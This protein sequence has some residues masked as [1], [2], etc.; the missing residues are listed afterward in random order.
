MRVVL[1]FLYLMCLPVFGQVPHDH[2]EHPKGN[3]AAMYQALPFY[4]EAC[5]LYSNGYIE[6]AK[7]SLHEA[8]NISFELTEAQLF[9]ADIY[10]DQGK[11][12]SAFLYYNSGIDFNIEQK[13]HYYFKLFES[14]LQLGQY[15][16]VKHNLGHFKKL[17]SNIGGEEPYEKE[18]KYRREDLEFYD[19]VLS[20]IYNYHYWKPVATLEYTFDEVFQYSSFQANRPIVVSD[21]SVLLL[22]NDFQ[23]KKGAKKVKGL[24]SNCSDLYITPMANLLF[25]QLK[26]EKNK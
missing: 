25:T 16:F 22:R 26:M 10:Y 4:N 11:I 14:G 20:M 6:K 12:D 7:R 9:L 18:F 13:P 3:S 8:I 24:P 1:V 21:Q 19:A 15:S 23:C 2:P 5:E 17:Y